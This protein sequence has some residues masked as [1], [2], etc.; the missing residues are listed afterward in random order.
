M[1]EKTEEQDFLM[2]YVVPHDKVARDIVEA[3]LP[4]VAEEAHVLFNLCFTKNGNFNGAY[5]VAHPQI[6][7]QDP[8][9]FFVTREMKII[10]NPVIV[11]HTQALVS[12]RE[13]C[14]SFPNNPPVITQR[15]NKC[16]MDFYTLIDDN[17]GGLSLSEKMHAVLDGHDAK[18]MQHENDHLDGKNIHQINKK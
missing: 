18:V 3:D 7:D 16:E 13:G 15:W 5:A 9:R 1:V 4:R 6:D 11:R 10:I 2:R 12:Y 17:K 14:T 8:L